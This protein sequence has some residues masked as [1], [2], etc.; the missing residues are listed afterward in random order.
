MVHFI[1]NTIL[2]LLKL[3]SFTFSKKIVKIQAKGIK[4]NEVI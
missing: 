4:I 2:V 3:C 1:K